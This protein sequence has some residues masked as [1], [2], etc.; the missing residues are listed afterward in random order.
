MIINLFLHFKIFDNIHKFFKFFF[1]KDF[2]KII[3]IIVTH[4]VCKTTNGGFQDAEGIDMI[5]MMNLTISSEKILSFY[6]H[7]NVQKF[8]V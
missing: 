7:C 5:Q 2:N 4:D 3:L 1:I 6:F 8:F